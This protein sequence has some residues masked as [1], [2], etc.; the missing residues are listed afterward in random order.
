[1]ST[2][3]CRYCSALM[4]TLHTVEADLA[5]VKLKIKVEENY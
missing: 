3:M 2:I 4:A 1:V 5:S